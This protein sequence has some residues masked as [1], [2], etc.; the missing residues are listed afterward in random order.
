MNGSLGIGDGGGGEKRAAGGGVR[1]GDGGEVGLS[2]V[3][4]LTAGAG[5]GVFGP[6]A[7][8]RA[9]VKGGIRQR[10]REPVM[11]FL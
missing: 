2:F 10:R 4:A 6:E 8:R 5:S 11:E 9:H 1:G 3:P 7:L